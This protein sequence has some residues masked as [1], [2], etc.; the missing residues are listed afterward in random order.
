MVDP[1][2]PSDRTRT[3]DRRA[4]DEAAVRRLYEGQPYPDLGAALKD[5]RAQLEPLLRHLGRRH[6]LTYL[7]AGCGT[8]HL[9]VGVAKAYPDWR[10][11]GID[12]SAASLDVAGRLAARH[13][14]EVTLAR[15]S[16]LDPLPFEIEAFDIISAQGTI[17]HTADPA[18]A[19]SALGRALAGDGRLSLHLYGLRLDRRKFDIKEMLSILEPDLSSHVRRFE[20]YRQLTDFERRWTLRRLASISPLDAYVAVKR[21]WTD[22]RR[23][24][25][26]VSWSPPWTADYREIDAPWVDHFC[27]PC[28]RAYEVP[29][30]RELLEAAGFVVEEMQGQGRHDARWLPPA[31]RDAYDR[32]D[33]WHRYRLM[34]LLNP[35]PLSF[36]MILRKAPAA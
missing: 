21:A 25:R 11:H 15:G 13:G 36:S 31:W 3:P 29:D 20:L 24:R 26:G 33:A 22:R 2:P 35:Y 18:A 14:V 34:E 27:H 9:L 28:E 10:C 12:L 6:G 1:S 16:Y 8:G 17:H 5:A 4:A 32:L 7:E 19:L 30:V 23:R